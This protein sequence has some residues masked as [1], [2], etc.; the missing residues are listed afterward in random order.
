MV[1]APFSRDHWKLY[2]QDTARGPLWVIHAISVDAGNH[3]NVRCAPFCDRFLCVAA[4]DAQ[5]PTTDMALGDL[6]LEMNLNRA[7]VRKAMLAAAL[8]VRSPLD[9]PGWDNGYKRARNVAVVGVVHA[10]ANDC[11]K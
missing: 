8:D 2:L 3:R 10:K 5:G 1:A 11:C 6:V 7:R 9:T 4:N